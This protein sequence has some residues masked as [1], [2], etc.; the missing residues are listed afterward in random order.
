MDLQALRNLLRLEVG[1]MKDN[2]PDRLTPDLCK[3]IGLPHGI[4]ADHR[5]SSRVQAASSSAAL[6]GQ[7][8]VIETAPRLSSTRMSAGVA[9]GAAGLGS[10]RAMNS[11][12]FEVPSLEPARKSCRQRCTTLALMP[13]AIATVATDAP[14]SQ[15]SASTCAFF[16]ALYRRRVFFSLVI[17]ST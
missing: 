12:V 3:S 1:D 2:G 6:T 5:S 4:D 15:H 14:G 10:G 11:L 8:T 17:A 13:W 7:V 16:V 9:A